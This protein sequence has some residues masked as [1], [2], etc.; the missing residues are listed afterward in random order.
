ME[1]VKKQQLFSAV[2]AFV[3]S[4]G[5]VLTTHGYLSDDIVQLIVGPGLTLAATLWGIWTPVTT[6]K[7]TQTR[8]TLAVQAGVSAAM[9]PTNS[10]NKPEDVSKETAKAVISIYGENK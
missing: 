9:D 3:I 4:I 1:E 5:M 10:I 8:E 7:K 2:R 6:E